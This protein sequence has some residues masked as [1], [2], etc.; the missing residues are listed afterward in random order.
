[1]GPTPN[2][3]TIHFYNETSTFW[4]RLTI[5]LAFLPSAKKYKNRAHSKTLKISHFQMCSLAAAF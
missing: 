5:V 1:M 4:Q 2:G 3:G